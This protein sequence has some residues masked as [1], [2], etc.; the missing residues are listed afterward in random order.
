MTLSPLI[1]EPLVRVFGHSRL[2]CA[3]DFRRR[4]RDSVFTCALDK[5]QLLSFSLGLVLCNLAMFMLLNMLTLQHPGIIWTIL[6]HG[7]V[8][9]P[10]FQK[11][12]ANL[13]HISRLLKTVIY[14]FFVDELNRLKS[15]GFK[16][17]FADIGGT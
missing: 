13:F 9:L 8:Y 3:N 6:N 4:S 10:L 16:S 1:S 7:R 11:Q 12:E 14:I 5:Q 17:C 15:D 2:K